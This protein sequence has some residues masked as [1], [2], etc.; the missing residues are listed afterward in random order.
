M[1]EPY[2]EILEG[3]NYLRPPPS[4]RHE[5]ICRR[6]H[7]RVTASLAGNAVARLLPPRSIVELSLTEK[8]RPDLALVASA[9]NKLWLAVEIVGTEDHRID[10]VTKKAI[11]ERR[12]MSRAYGWW[13]RATTTWKSITAAAT[14]SL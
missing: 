10:T 14:A 8:I 7:A 6:L 12:S 3:Q 9:T 4:P 5:E 2:E 13:T 11:Y 1:S